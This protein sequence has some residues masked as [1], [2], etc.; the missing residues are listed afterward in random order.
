MT[1]G[2]VSETIKTKKILSGSRRAI[3]S[4]AGV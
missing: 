4:I 2:G 3:E 1:D